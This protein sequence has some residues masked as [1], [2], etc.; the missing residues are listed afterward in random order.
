M[1]YSYVCAWWFELGGRAR[2]G[3]DTPE[4]HSVH[5]DMIREPTHPPTRTHIHIPRVGLEELSDE[6]LRLLLRDAQALRGRRGPE[7]V[8]DPEGDGLWVICFV[9]VG[10]GWL[11]DRPVGVYVYLRFRSR[12]LGR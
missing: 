4:R 8:D 9:V 2:G 6:S 5:V 10:C 3:D 1:L 7:A 11:G 12:R